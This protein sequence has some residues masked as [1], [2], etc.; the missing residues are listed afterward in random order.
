[1]S[2]HVLCAGGSARRRNSS[3]TP[4]RRDPRP[5]ASPQMTTAWNGIAPTRTPLR[6]WRSTI[7]SAPRKYTHAPRSFASGTARLIRTGVSCSIASWLPSRFRGTTNGTLTRTTSPSEAS[8]ST[9]V[10]SRCD[11]IA[12]MNSGS[13]ASGSTTVSVISDDS[14]RP[15]AVSTTT[16]RLPDSIAGQKFRAAPVASRSAT[17]A[18]VGSSSTAGSWKPGIRIDVPVDSFGRSRHSLRQGPRLPRARPRCLPPAFRTSP[19]PA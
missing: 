14:V 15:V 2:S 19:V 8:E 18:D 17:A 7:I 9:T 11:R 10:F 12:A 4:W 6:F 13:T 3:A 1:M 16:L 5:A